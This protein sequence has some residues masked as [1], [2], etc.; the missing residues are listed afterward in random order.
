MG[1]EEIIERIMQIYRQLP[2]EAQKQFEEEVRKRSEK[3]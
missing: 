1:K 2:P 3:H